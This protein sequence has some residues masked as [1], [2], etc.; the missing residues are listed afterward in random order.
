[1]LAAAALAAMGTAAA[2]SPKAIE[3]IEREG[4]TIDAKM[5]NDAKNTLSKMK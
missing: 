4:I 5:L 2:C 1:M 3:R